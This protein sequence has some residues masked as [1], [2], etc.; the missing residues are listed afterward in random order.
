MADLTTL[1]AAMT[2]LTAKVA[3]QTSV[4]ASAVTLIQ[5]MVLK[6]ADLSA[7]IASLQA[8]TVTQAQLDAIAQQAS[9]LSTSLDAAT[10]PL[11]TAVTTNTPAA[12]AT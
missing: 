6:I 12:P 5:G 1:T 3:A 9:G 7:Q 10:Q 11:A 2:D 8:G 4:D